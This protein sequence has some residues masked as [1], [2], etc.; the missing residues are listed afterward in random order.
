MDSDRRASQ[1][2]RVRTL[3]IAKFR[4]A[5]R[6]GFQVRSASPGVP[7]RAGRLGDRQATDAAQIESEPPALPSRP[8]LIRANKGETLTTLILRCKVT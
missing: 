7:E 8:R 2:R 6:V 3:I 1:P 4:R 5:A